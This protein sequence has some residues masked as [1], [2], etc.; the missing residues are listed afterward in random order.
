MPVSTTT[1]STYTLNV[2]MVGVVGSFVGMPLDALI[3]GAF[4]G[5]IIHGLSK[6]G[7]RG[8]GLVTVVTSTLLAGAFSPAVVGWLVH[9]FDFGGAE[10]GTAMLKPLVPVLIGA[11]WPWI[12]PMVHQGAK[13][14]FDAV[15]NRVIKLIEFIGGSK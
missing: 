8:Q 15:V 10:A 11:T 3:L 14:V 12:A 13:Q 7:T 4:A 1:V 5:G 9:N 6:A 2:G